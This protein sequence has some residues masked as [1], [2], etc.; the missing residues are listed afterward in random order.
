[1]AAETMDM[2]C[3]VYYTVFIIIFI[4]INKH[5]T[6]TTLHGPG[7]HYPQAAGWQGRGIVSSPAR[8]GHR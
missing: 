4:L 1:M 5:T 2:M 7:K 6:Q 3:V 8:A